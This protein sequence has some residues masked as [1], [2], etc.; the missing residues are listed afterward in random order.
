MST[1]SNRLTCTLGLA[2]AALAP[3]IASAASAAATPAKPSAKTACEVAIDRFDAAHDGKGDDAAI[4]AALALVKTCA[5]PDKAKARAMSRVGLAHYYR[6]EFAD[7]LDALEQSVDLNPDD[8][9]LRMS[10]CG[11]YTEAG[12]HDAAIEACAAGLHL[13]EQ[14]DDGSAEKHDKV[15]KLGFNLALAKV[16]RHRNL[17]ADPSI[18]EMFDAYRAAHADSAWVYQLLGAWVWDCDDDFDKGLA[19]YK[20]SCSLGQESACEQ[21]RYT[22]QCRCEARI[23]GSD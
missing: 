15:L 3:V 22:E 16:R 12:K 19:L 7:A 14:Q 21:V 20:K 6:Q 9:T 13:A 11:V 23:D 10:L 5:T 18:Y 1:R 2:L 17:C 4:D 8:P